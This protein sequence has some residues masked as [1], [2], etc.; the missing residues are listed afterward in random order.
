[1]ALTQ[2]QILSNSLI[3]LGHEPI[4]SIEGGDALVVSAISAY[5]IKLPAAL[6][7]NNWRFA[8]QLAQL[9]KLNITPPQPWLSIYQLPAGWLK[10]LRLYPNIYQWDIYS[11]NQLF[12]VYDDELWAEYVFQP[13]VSQFP[14]HFVDYFTYEISAYLALT[15]ANK[16]DYY[17]ALESKRTSTLG[18]AAAIEAQNRPQF[19]QNLFPVLDNRYIGGIIGNSIS[20]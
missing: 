9:S 12:A 10:L 13:D 4:S 5:D 8:T 6:A 11:G 15:N 16:A 1:M 17:S 2:V 14:A 3:Q 19:T 7:A 20:S 18:I